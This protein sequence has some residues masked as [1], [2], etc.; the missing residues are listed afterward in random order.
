MDGGEDIIAHHTFVQHDGILEVIPFPWHECH[1][2]VL[3]YCQL[4]ILSDI[5]FGKDLTLLHLLSHFTYRSQIDGGI[6]VGLA[7][8]WNVIRF[9]RSVETGEIL[10]FA[11]FILYLDGRG[12]HVD[13]LT[14]ALS[15]DL[16]TGVLDKL[17][18]QSG[19]HHG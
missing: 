6:L 8:F 3:A 17:I 18:L 19:A 10:I 1:F 9:L 12:I 13:N 11:T 16:R 2:Q 14:V 5:S 4:T 7:E 15:H